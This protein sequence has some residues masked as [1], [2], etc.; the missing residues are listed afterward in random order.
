MFA[1][2]SARRDFFRIG[3]TSVSVFWESRTGGNTSYVYGGDQNGDGGTSND[4]I[5]VPRDRSEMNF[6]PYTQTIGSGASA[7]TFVYSAQQQADA[8]EA[9]IKQDPYLSSH[10][11]EYVERN[12]AFLP[13][14]S[15]IDFSIAQQLGRRIGSREHGVELRLDVLNFGNLLSGN[16]G[17]GYAFTTTQPLL[18]QGSDAQGRPLYRLR[19]IDGQ[20]IRESFVR[21][22]GVADV[23]RMQLGLRYTF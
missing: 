14:T 22:A 21:T 23:H 19:N 4:L 20:L 10:R 2:L 5:Y 13:M 3:T 12:A 11:G 18:P 16:F 15:R 17:T 6:Q 1:V 8:W 7:Q 9:F